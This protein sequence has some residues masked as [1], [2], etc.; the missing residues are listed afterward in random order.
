MNDDD[1][2]RL[3]LADPKLAGVYF[4]TEDDLD[5]LATATTESGL[6]LRRLDLQTCHDKSALLQQ[7]AQV[8]T[9]PPGQGRN[10]D[11]LNDQLRDLSWLPANGYVL[12]FAH[13]E[14]LRDADEAAFDTLLEILEQASAAWQAQSVAFWVFLALPESDFPTTQ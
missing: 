14:A 6:L 3:D 4:V 11:A 12:L 1:D 2:A 5:T 10:W 9:L 8:L 7:L 13:A